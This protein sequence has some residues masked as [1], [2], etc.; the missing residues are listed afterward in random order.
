MA[1]M[2]LDPPVDSGRNKVIQIKNYSIILFTK[3]F[4]K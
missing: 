1:P 3:L 2:D 4:T